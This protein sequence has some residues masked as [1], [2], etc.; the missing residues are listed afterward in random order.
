MSAL[1]LALAAVGAAW[2]GYQSARWGGVQ[3]TATADANASRLES[4]RA[5][6]QG[7]QQ[8]QVDVA[9]FFQAV[10]AF[11]ADDQDLA[12]FYR[13]RFR[14]EFSPVYDDWLALD[15]ANNPEAPLSPFDLDDYRV[16]ALE[17]AERLSDEADALVTESREARERAQSYTISLVLFASALFF[18]GIST[19]FASDRARIS[20]LALGMVLFIAVAA[21]MGTLPKSVAL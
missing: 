8:V 14:D 13:D 1:L 2:A 3:A 19:K 7:G 4:S 5:Q 9:L 10:N 21:W 16:A 6:T 20:V 15:P 11:A 18:A 17:E 12:N